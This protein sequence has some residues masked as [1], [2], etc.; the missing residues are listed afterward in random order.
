[1]KRSSDRIL[2]THVGSLVKTPEIID[3]MRAEVMGE[4]FDRDSFAR[5]L[6]N[7]VR[8]VVKKQEEVG[9]DVPSDGEFGKSSWMG[10]VWERLDGLELSDR[11]PGDADWFTLRNAQFRGFQRA[12]DRVE[13]IMWMP[14][15]PSG[16]KPENANILRL[17][18]C[19]SPI[20]YKGHAAIRRDIENFKAALGDNR[21]TEALLPVVAPCSCCF[22]GMNRYYKSEEEFL[23]AAADALR[24]E[25]QA[26]VDAGLI[27]QVDDAILP[28]LY[29]AGAPGQDLQKYLKWA[30]TCED[31]L[32]H[33]LRDIP[34]DRVRYH[35]C[36]GSQ[37]APHTWDIPL[38]DIVNVVLRVKA[39][40]Y[41]I[42]AANP[43]HEHEWQVWENVPLPSGKILIPGVVTH[44]TNVVEHPELIA[45]RIENFAR[46]VGR[47]NVMAGTDCGFSQGW[48]WARVHEEVQWAKLSALV[49][50]AK[51]ASQHLWA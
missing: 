35:I 45:W 7:G 26:I 42:E 51:L 33:A 5:D 21:F 17:F 32:N 2:T 25:Y 39:Q 19:T 31:A 1:M 43:R 3:A 44:S 37:N 16:R 22:P 9:V 8:Q 36:W 40:A 27:L 4:V 50:G 6:R 29:V 24:E 46:L 12:Y 15:L 38:S 20:K 14:D 30:A 18:A 28:M 47:E 48:N 49:Q 41:C 11:V 23:F 34:E 13:T 10:Y